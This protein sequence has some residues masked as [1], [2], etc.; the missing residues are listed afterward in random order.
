MVWWG[1]CIFVVSFTTTKNI[2][3][4]S[5]SSLI[6]MGSPIVGKVQQKRCRKYYGIC[7]QKLAVIGMVRLNCRQHPH[8]RTSQT[9][10]RTDTTPIKKCDVAQPNNTLYLC[11]TFNNKI[12]TRYNHVKRRT[13]TRLAATR[14]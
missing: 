6:L 14:C 10:P 3:N 1:G 13:K 2:K 8:L 4:E 12:K 5:N 11:I 7:Q 9:T